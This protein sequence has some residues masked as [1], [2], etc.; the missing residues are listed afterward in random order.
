MKS[1]LRAAYNR[2]GRPPLRRVAAALGLLAAAAL[3]A[4]AFLGDQ[5]LVSALALLMSLATLGGLALVWNDGRK[6]RAEVRASAE[7]SEVTFRRIL[8]AIEVERLA[9]ERRYREQN[10]R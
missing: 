10:R 6:A 2:L 4:V 3:V 9:S 1:I 7:R 5:R 8:A